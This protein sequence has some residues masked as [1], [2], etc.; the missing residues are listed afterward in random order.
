MLNL[1]TIG[2]GSIVKKFLASIAL[3][4]D[5]YNLK[6]VY[7]RDLG[8]GKEFAAQF[9]CTD[10][11]TDLN[12]LANREDVDAVYI[13]SP[14]SLHFEQALLMLKNK[15]H[16]LLEKP[17][18]VKAEQLQ[19]LHRCAQENGVYILEAII[20][21]Y[22]PSRSILR[23]AVKEIGDIQSARFQFCQYSV[24][25][26]EYLKGERPNVFTAQFAGGSIMDL[27]IYCIYPAIDLFGEP[28]DIKVTSTILDTGVDSNMTCV[29]DYGEKIVNIISSKTA[30]SNIPSEILG[31]NGSIQIGLISKYE[32][33]FKF[34][35]NNLQKLV[36]ELPK[37]EYMGYEAHFLYTLITNPA[38]VADEYEYLKEIS[39][40][41]CRTLEKIRRIAGLKF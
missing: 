22:L 35:N 39:L 1:A 40:K 37:E 32:N 8:R 24:R 41:V 33:I 7:S 30:Q 17:A 2:T 34:T 3:L 36:G 26:N 38:L 18:T 29:F 19:Q 15:K 31:T 4:G 28:K 23:Q 10:V 11:V 6:V 21:M 20:P 25:Y 27:G 5:E 13:A 9:G 16:V 12:E 14:N